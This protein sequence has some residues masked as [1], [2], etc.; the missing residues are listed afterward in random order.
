VVA[1]ESDNGAVRAGEPEFGNLLRRHRRAAGM[2]QE[3]LADR[4]GLSVDAIAALE[5]GRRRAPRPLTARLL[6]K[7]LDL[8]GPVRAAFL[9]VAAG[10]SS[11]AFVAPVAPPAPT[12]E[13]VGRAAELAESV[14]R[15]TETPTRLLTLSGPGGIGKS[16]LAMALANTCAERLDAKVAWV[17]LES[18]VDG[19]SVA[20]TIATALGLRPVPGQDPFDQ[21]AAAIGTKR[22][23]VVLDNCEHV[24]D[25]CA[26][27]TAELLSRCP[28]LRVLATSRELLGVPGE[29]VQI[30]RPLSVPPEDC[31]TE[32]LIGSPAVRLFLARAAGRGVQAID[33]GMTE[34][35]RVVRRLDGMPLAI[36]LAAARLNVLT[37][38]EIAREL[39]E[40]FQILHSQVRV[41]P[42]RHRTM[43]RA[44]A[45]SYD[46][47]DARDQRCLAAL[48][49]F[50]GGWTRDAA[51]AVCGDLVTEDGRSDLAAGPEVLELIGRLVDRSLVTARREGPA[52]RFDILAAI[53]DFA[54]HRLVQLDLVDAVA[55]RHAEHYADLVARA[56]PELRGSDQAAWLNRLEEDLDNIRS[57]IRWSID[58][59]EIDLALRLVGPLWTF[60]Y[61][62]GHYSEGR[63]WLERALDAGPGERGLV[64]AKAMLGAGMLAFLQCE[65]GVATRWIEAAL[66]EYRTHD[67]RPGTALC[68]QRLGSLARERTDYDRATELHRASRQLYADLADRSGL[69]WADNHIGFVAWLRGDLPTAQDHCAAALET[70][71]EIGDNEGVAWSLISLGAVALYRGDLADAE[72]M[73][74]ESRELSQRLGYREGVAWSLNQLGVVELRRGRTELAVHL[75]D[76]SL[77]EHRDLGDR[78][79]MASVIETLADVARVRGRARYAAFLLGAAATV[80]EQI[81]APVPWCE[82]AER[83]ACLEAV[84]NTLDVEGFDAAWDVGAKAPL[85][86]VAMG[87]PAE[88]GPASESRS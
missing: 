69:A 81:G 54:H 37:I 88:P 40:S 44:I 83:D 55:H 85:H 48:S 41:G 61:L 39:D 78:W 26:K 12:N 66:D 4:A 51:E 11:E 7:A 73:L 43:R 19:S 29:A 77:A 79:R 33:Q 84:R 58:R 76:E 9:E 5:R 23:L 38:G 63:E 27:L 25:T 22:A 72:A 68:L 59:A 28:Q 36:E 18:L 21:V 62:R 71:R 75:L 57:A 15:L 46:L 30:V 35:A 60:C 16:R 42:H 87:Y 20:A 13:L 86:A 10:A 32:Q 2:S 3:D 34:V 53:R 70:F 8:D 31:P 6:A 80:R 64:R 56:E 65:Y 47:L 17:S 24:I 74:S 49:V 52:A 14:L 82:V 67:D 1:V 50:V 45:W